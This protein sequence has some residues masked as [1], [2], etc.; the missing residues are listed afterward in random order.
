[1]NDYKSYYEEEEKP[2]Q[3]PAGRL[4]IGLIVGL[5]IGGAI[6]FA[7]G[8]GTNV[9]GGIAL[10]NPRIY[11]VATTIIAVAVVSVA[12]AVKR[13]AMGMNGG[14]APQ[15]IAMRLVVMGLAL[16]LALAFGVY[17]LFAQ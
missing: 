1:M 7:L 3:N 6:G 17:F 9:D 14:D 10:G 15:S 8:I 4:V 13:T 5:I 16:F 2:S 11:L 12:I